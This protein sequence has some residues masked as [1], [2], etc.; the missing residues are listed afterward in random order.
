VNSLESVRA[1][2]AESETRLVKQFQVRKGKS[3]P[4]A[5]VGAVVLSSSSQAQSRAVLGQLLQSDHSLKIA[6]CHMLELTTDNPNDSQQILF[7][8]ALFEKHTRR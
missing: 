4:V 7:A 6:P 1:A 3:G 8:T 5:V 2:A